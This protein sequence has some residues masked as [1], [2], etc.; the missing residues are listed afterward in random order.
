MISSW[1]V[2]EILPSLHSAPSRLI[3]A[4][5]LPSLQPP[6]TFIVFGVKG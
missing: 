2:L 3:A 5:G 1:R 6:N 4:F